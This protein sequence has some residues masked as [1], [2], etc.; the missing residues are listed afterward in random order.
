MGV[1]QW[2]PASGRASQAT[3]VADHTVVMVGQQ[4]GAYAHGGITMG[5][6]RKKVTGRTKKTA[7]KGLPVRDA[8]QQVI[9]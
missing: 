8:H 5:T 3:V 1:R 4:A 9:A 7:V 6:K 2:T